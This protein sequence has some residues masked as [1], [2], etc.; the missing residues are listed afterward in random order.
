M[1]VHEGVGLS[2]RLLA[3]TETQTRIYGACLLSEL[4]MVGTPPPSPPPLYVSLT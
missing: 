2:L 1:I 4:A 3:A